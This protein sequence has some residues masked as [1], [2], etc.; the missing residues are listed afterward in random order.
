M[1]ARTAVLAVVTFLVGFALGQVRGLLP[2]DTSAPSR[3]A[4]A[5]RAER[6]I[7]PECAELA[8]LREEVAA[9]GKEQA[10]FDLERVRTE[11][12]DA[13]P[14]WPT[15]TVETDESPGAVIAQTLTRAGATVVHAACDEPPCFFVV[16]GL[17]LPR[18]TAALEPVESKPSVLEA[19]GDRFIVQGAPSEHPRAAK[20]LAAVRAALAE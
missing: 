7:A 4:P 1:N 17:P 6:V 13:L 14:A 9:L 20:R 11:R 8:S 19:P 10:G 3:P 15:E 2:S 18:L 12:G 16:E 5:P